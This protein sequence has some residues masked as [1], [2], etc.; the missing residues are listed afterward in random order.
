MKDF[1]LNASFHYWP[2]SFDKDR[3]E[4]A[5]AM[6]LPFESE[7]AVK[8]YLHEVSIVKRKSWEDKGFR[9]RILSEEVTELP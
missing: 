6:V 1:Q 5:I 9:C 3:K 2:G 8:K 4:D 7:E